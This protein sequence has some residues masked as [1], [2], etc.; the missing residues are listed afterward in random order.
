M[1]RHPGT[2]RSGLAPSDRRVAREGRQRISQPRQAPFPPL[3]R[4]HKEARCLCTRRSARSEDARSV[5]PSGPA[6]P[7]GGSSSRSSTAP[8]HPW[9]SC[10]HATS[11]RRAKT[12][13]QPH[14]A[15]CTTASSAGS[16]QQRQLRA[17]PR[18]GRCNCSRTPTCRTPRPPAT[19]RDIPYERRNARHI[20]CSQVCDRIVQMPAGTAAAAAPAQRWSYSAARTGWVG[21]TRIASSRASRAATTGTPVTS[22]GVGTG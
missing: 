15:C 14:P 11:S 5:R 2:H 18:D 12:S 10:W 19:A 1:V 9:R 8:A 4:P 7:A 20:A 21:T 17:R 3:T 16:T 13:R 22:S 6:T